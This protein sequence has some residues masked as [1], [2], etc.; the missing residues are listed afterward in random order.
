MEVSGDVDAETAPMLLVALAEA[1]DVTPRVCCDLRGVGFFG[2]DGANVLAIAHVH[3]AH[4]RGAFS[5]R[6]VHGF[7][8]RVLEITGL[9]LI[10]RM[11]DQV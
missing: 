7:T 8:A 5:V 1:I 9:N 4:A 10:L 6:G 11:D 3:A 2:A